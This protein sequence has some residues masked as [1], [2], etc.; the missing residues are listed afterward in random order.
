MHGSR[1]LWAQHRLARASAHC[2]IN[3]SR[4]ESGERN[5]PLLEA[6][7]LEARIFKRNC[8]RTTAL[9]PDTYKD[10]IEN[11]SCVG[12]GR[13]PIDLVASLRYRA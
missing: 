6:A 3:G 12:E 2:Q 11:E 4:E 7:S 8:N 13:V 9:A 10:F 1:G 5:A